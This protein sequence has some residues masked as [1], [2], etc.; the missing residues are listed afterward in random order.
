MKKILYIL[1]VIILISA[2]TVAFYSFQ[3]D[4]FNPLHSETLKIDN[5]KRKF[6]YHIPKNI[7]QNPK[8]IFVLHGS[9]I[10]ATLMQL[11]TGHQFNKLADKTKDVIIVYPEGYKKYWNDC[12]KAGARETKEKPE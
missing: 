3:W 1:L 4:I 2:L 12:K 8:L 10:S 5:I 6:Y 7:T 9:N 11:V